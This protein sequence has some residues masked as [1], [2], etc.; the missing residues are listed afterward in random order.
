MKEVFKTI[1]IVILAGVSIY[2]AYQFGKVNDRMTVLNSQDSLQNIDV[3]GFDHAVHDLNLQFVGR[4]HHIQEFQSA[5]EKYGEKLDR[6]RDQFDMKIDSLGM[7]LGEFKMNTETKLA[8][9][10]SKISD[11]SEQLTTNKREAD[12]KI[13]DNRDLIRKMNRTM[14]QLDTKIKELEKTK[15]DIPADDGKS[16]KRR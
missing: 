9:L 15:M 4:G 3:E 2:F 10:D 1:L 11:I 6:T 13:L 8:Q 14:K 16:G 5:L 7:L 12:R